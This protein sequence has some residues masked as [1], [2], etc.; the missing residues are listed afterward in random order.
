MGQRV[1]RKGG[2]GRRE[3]RKEGEGKKKRKEGGREGRKF[4]SVLGIMLSN[5]CTTSLLT[6]TLGSTLY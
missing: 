2:K 5:L 6:T 4:Y 1:K 3:E